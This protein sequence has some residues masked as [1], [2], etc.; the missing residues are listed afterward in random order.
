MKSN[1]YTQK[2]QLK[3]WNIETNN[4]NFNCNK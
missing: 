1:Y 3:M 2:Q 4:D